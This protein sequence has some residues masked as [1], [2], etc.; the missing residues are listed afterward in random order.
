MAR[1]FT[2]HMIPSEVV[3]RLR[4]LGHDVV[5][6]RD[7]S[8]DGPKDDVQLLAAATSHR[9]LVTHD[10]LDFEMLHDAWRRWSAAW[11]S[12]A[13]HSGILI[14]PQGWPP[15]KTTQEIHQFIESGVDLTTR[16]YRLHRDGRWAE[17]PLRAAPMPAP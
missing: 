13:I 16:L 2:D 6:T 12:V 11:G 5:S 9:I 7:L 14:V 4:A 1:I 3:G 15:Q 10:I 17:R 8:L